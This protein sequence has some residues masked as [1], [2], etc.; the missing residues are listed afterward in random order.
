VDPGTVSSASS[1]PSVTKDAV[2]LLVLALGLR[3]GLTE[4][5]TAFW[6]F[7]LYVHDGEHRVWRRGIV[8]LD[9]VVLGGRL[10][11]GSVVD[12]GLWGLLDG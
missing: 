2:I 5:R 10:V 3:S 6:S 8:V 9:E 12:G 1:G 11:D 4:G 7:R